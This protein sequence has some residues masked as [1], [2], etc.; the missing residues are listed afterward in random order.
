[1]GLAHEIAPP[2]ALATALS[3]LD[4]PRRAPTAKDADC[5]T[6]VTAAV[7]AELARASAALARSDFKAAKTILEDIDKRFAGLASPRIT[8]LANKLPK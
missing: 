5:W 7:D 4:E 6:R 3:D 8:E 1:M 2:S